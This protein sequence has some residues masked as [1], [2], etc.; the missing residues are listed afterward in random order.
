MDE[1]TKQLCT[2][3]FAKENGILFWNDTVYIRDDVP[4]FA[5][6]EMR[7]V[8]GRTFVP[9][10]LSAEAFDG[11]DFILFLKMK[12]QNERVLRFEEDSE[13]MA[14]QMVVEGEECIKNGDILTGNLRELIKNIA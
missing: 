10:T 12:Q 11:L 9:Q 8:L 13:E 14:I 2:S 4:A 1:L 3:G 6:L 5:L 7:R